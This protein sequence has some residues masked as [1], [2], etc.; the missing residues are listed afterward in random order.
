MTRRVTPRVG[1]DMRSARPSGGRFF[2]G[3]YDCFCYLPREVARIVAQ[4]RKRWP[5]VRILLRADS[6]FAREALMAWCEANR[7]DFLFGLAR[8]ERLVQEIKPALVEAAVESVATGQA[9]RRFREFSWRTLDSWSRD[10]RVIGKAEW[11]GGEANPRFIVCRVHR[12]R[13]TEAG[14]LW[15]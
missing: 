14:R 2:L 15:T 9:A 12:H 11:T 8:N 13:F 4:I 7:V 1:T 5:R 3:Y 6:G 10:R